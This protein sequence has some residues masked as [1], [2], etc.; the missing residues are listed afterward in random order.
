MHS[1]SS[2]WNCVILYILQ[3]LA[4]VGHHRT[5]A[6]MRHRVTCQL[7][8]ARQYLPSPSHHIGH[9]LGSVG[10]DQGQQLVF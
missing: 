9:S 6:F 7:T 8:S 10:C 1:S 2:S 4:Y 3:V 5:C